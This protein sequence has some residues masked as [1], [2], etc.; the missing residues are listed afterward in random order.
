MSHFSSSRL[1]LKLA[2][3]CLL[4]LVDDEGVIL[5]SWVVKLPASTEDKVLSKIG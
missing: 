2:T 3:L 4:V 1:F 5:D